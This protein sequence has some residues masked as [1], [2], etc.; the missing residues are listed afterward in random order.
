MKVKG[1]KIVIES[2]SEID[3]LQDMIETYLK[4]GNAAGY[5][6]ELETIKEQLDV[7]YISW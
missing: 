7:L 5:K 1:D 6:T 4:T 3:V 2:R